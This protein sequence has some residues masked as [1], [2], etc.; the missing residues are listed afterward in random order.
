MVMS[1][2][3]RFQRHDPEVVNVVRLTPF[4]SE[5]RSILAMELRSDKQTKKPGILIIGGIV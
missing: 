4:T 3:D 2:V 5:N 1:A